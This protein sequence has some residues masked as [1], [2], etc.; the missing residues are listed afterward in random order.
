MAKKFTRRSFLNQ[1]LLVSSNLVMFGCILDK[2]KDMTP[3][4]IIPTKP[5]ELIPAG[6]ARRFKEAPMLSALV[7]EGKLPPVEARLPKVPFIREVDSIGIYGGTLY[8]DSRSQGGRFTL[9]GALISSP[10]ETDNKGLLVRPHMCEKV[11]HNK[12]YTEFEFYIRE[13]LKWSDGVELSSD[14]VIWWWEHEQNNK[15]LYPEGPKTAWKIGKA[16]A[17]FEKINRWAFRI[18]F[19][20]PFRPLINVSVHEWMSFSNFFCQPAHYMKQFHID[21]NPDANKLAKSFGYEAWYQLYKER[22][23]YMRPHA[24]KPGLSPWVRTITETT[25]DV[26]MRNPYYAEVDPEGNQLPYVD[27]IYVSVVE[28]RKLQDARIATGGVSLGPTV[29]SQINIYKKNEKQGDFHI[30]KWTYSNSSECMF[31]FNLNHKDP[32]L[33][34]I[35]ND[36]RFRQA[37]SL[38]IDRKKI[39]DSLYFGLAK[40]CQATLNP[41]VS[42]FDTR[43]LDHYAKYDI[44]G[45]NALLDDMGLEWDDK[46][47]YRLRP[48]GKRFKTV[49]LYNQ[50]SFP[51]QITELVRE[52]WSKTGMDVIL[53]ESDLQ[54][55]KQRCMSGDHDCTCWNADLTEEIAAYL[56]WMTKW[57]PNNALYY[58]LDW[59]Y[60][61]YSDGKNGQEPPQKW[62]DQ[63][64][65]MASWYQAP[66]DEEYRRLGHDVWDFFSRELVCIGTVGYAP[67]PVVVKNGLMNVPES[68]KMG[69]GTVWAKSYKVQTFYW[70]HPEAHT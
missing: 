23:E 5:L 21:F 25:H 66:D 8:D 33:K 16:Y 17:R 41:E 31:A 62:K 37:M 44:D 34:S 63:F 12:D 50:Q 29:L 45:A 7:K 54:F 40:E 67:I 65:R 56:P 26:Y 42:Y 47:E 1:T 18:I 3:D 70:D 60:W 49:I 68:I 57:S 38:A 59:W 69:Y 20:L 24:G 30:N 13:G 6:S 52:D 64:N 53:K 28:D 14:D 10:Q 58:A 32:V 48:D 39:N 46:Q 22:E 35:Y 55:R 19:P 61:Y 36:L 51:L 11:L 27:R 2:Q 9:D 15:Q 4:K 43:W